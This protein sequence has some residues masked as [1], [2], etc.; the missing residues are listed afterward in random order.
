MPNVSSKQYL[1]YLTSTSNPFFRSFTYRTGQEGLDYSPFPCLKR[2][3]HHYRTAY[4]QPPYCGC[5]SRRDIPESTGYTKHQTAHRK[6]SEQRKLAGLRWQGWFWKRCNIFFRPLNPSKQ[7]TPIL[8]W[9]SRSWW[10]GIA[11]ELF[12]RCSAYSRAFALHTLGVWTW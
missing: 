7:Q 1:H 8:P 6:N 3:I 10:E 2:I 12:R 5:P 9:V 4:P 11:V